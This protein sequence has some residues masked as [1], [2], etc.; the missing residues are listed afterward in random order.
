MKA[1]IKADTSHA[2]FKKAGIPSGVVLRKGAWQKAKESNPAG[3]PKAHRD[4]SKR[5]IVPLSP[6]V[7]EQ[8][9]HDKAGGK[10]WSQTAE[11]T[12]LAQAYVEKAVKTKFI[13]N[14]Q[15]REILKASLLTNGIAFS[16]QATAKIEE[17][18]GMQ[19]VVAAGIMT[20]RFIDLDKHSQ[21]VP[22]SVDL[23]EL[24]KVGRTIEEIES[25]ITINPSDIID[26]GGLNE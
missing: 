13:N 2:Q 9:A 10:S 22:N 4:H 16:E 15:G 24:A 3:S 21:N 12:G 1:K 6:S 5:Q 11:A 14:Q 17:L 18:N 19:S 25:G 20:Q 8:A 26:I 23:E 7:F